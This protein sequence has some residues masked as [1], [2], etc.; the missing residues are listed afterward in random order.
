MSEV[1]TREQRLAKGEC[2]TSSTLL[3]QIEDYKGGVVFAVRNDGGD[4]AMVQVT[5][6]KVKK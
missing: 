5:K 1:L 3:K 2:L 4:I 6:P